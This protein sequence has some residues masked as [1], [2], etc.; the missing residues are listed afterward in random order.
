MYNCRN[1]FLIIQTNTFFYE[2][3]H[4]RINVSYNDQYNP[5]GHVFIQ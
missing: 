1:I 4:A 5:N 3:V 2:P